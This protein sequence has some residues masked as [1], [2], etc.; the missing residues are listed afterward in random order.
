MRLLFHMIDIAVANSWLLCRQQ[1]NSLEVPQRKPM[2]LCEFKLKL[3]C[4]LLLSGKT[5]G[6]KRKSL[7]NAVSV[8][9]TPKKKTGKSTKPILDKDVMLNGTDHFPIISSSRGTY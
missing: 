2:S 6:R 5:K 1:A 7:G 8:A 9:Y 4:S 3:S